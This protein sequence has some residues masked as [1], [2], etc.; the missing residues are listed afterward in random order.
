MPDLSL[1]SILQWMQAHAVA[2][3]FVWLALENVLF[4]GIVMPGLS[5]LMVAGVLLYTGDVSPLP[6][7][8]AAVAG[9][10]LGDNLNF[11]IGRWGLRRWHFLQRVLDANDDVRSFID[12]YPMWIYIFFHFP[13][14]LRSAFPLTLG[15]MRYPVHR[16]LLIDGLAAPL[17]VGAFVGLGYGLA[18]VLLGQRTLLGALHEITQWGNAVALTGSLVFA[19]GTYRFLR[20]LWR[21]ARHPTTDGSS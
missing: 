8:T 1:P 16:W 14:Y 15:A 5:V 10:Y 2:L 4:F 9:T 21:A 19:Y 20:I 17:F 6:I 18:S 12:R 3:V 13:V 11:A 7:L